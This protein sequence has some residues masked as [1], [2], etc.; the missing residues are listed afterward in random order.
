MVRRPGE[1]PA[2]PDGIRKGLEAGYK[3][4]PR[5][6][7]R[8]AG[9]R[10]QVQE[11]KERIAKLEKGLQSTSDSLTSFR[12]TVQGLPRM[13]S[14]LNKAKRET[15]IVLDEIIDSLAEGRRLLVDAIKGLDELKE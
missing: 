4:Y 15:A 8:R 1:L 7:Y 5:S 9:E 12:E 13:T 3:A 6:V 2:F 11:A 10:E 14:T